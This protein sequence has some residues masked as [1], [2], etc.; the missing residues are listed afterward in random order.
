MKN[1]LICPNCGEDLYLKKTD[2][3]IYI[4]YTGIYDLWLCGNCTHIKILDER[5]E[6]KE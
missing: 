5:F 4:D 6:A 1:K 3:N 2:T